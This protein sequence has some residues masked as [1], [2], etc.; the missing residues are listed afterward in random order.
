MRR[1]VEER[2]GKRAVE[3]LE[4]E[5]DFFLLKNIV[6][7]YLHK[8]HM[9][10]VTSLFMEPLVVSCTPKKGKQSAMIFGRNQPVQQREWCP[11]QK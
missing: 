10:A 7:L 6:I 4:E 1:A 9:Q 3:M 2:G 11:G 8:R 5:M